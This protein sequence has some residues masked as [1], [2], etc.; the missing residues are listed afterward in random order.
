[1]FLEMRFFRS[2]LTNVALSFTARK[3]ENDAEKRS[4]D[5]LFFNDK[6]AWI[7]LTTFSSARLVGKNKNHL[8]FQPYLVNDLIEVSGWLFLLIGLSKRPQSSIF[9]LIIQYFIIRDVFKISWRKVR[10]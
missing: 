10:M 2:W 5:I 4:E 6:F 7:G 1:M 8:Y 9:Y 3:T